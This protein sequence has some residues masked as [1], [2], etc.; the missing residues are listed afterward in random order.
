VLP[1]QLHG[2]HLQLLRV[3]AAKRRRHMLRI[4]VQLAILRRGMA[5]GGSWVVLS[6]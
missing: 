6:P 5:R 3:W 1:G 2:L 4:I